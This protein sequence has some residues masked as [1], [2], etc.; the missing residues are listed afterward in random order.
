MLFEG[1]DGVGLAE[2]E[3]DDIVRFLRAGQAAGD[4]R[5]VAAVGAASR[6]GRCVADELRA[7]GRA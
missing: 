1:G 6:G 2:A 7:A 5:G 3:G 4:D